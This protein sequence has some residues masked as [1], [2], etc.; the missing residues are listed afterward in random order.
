MESAALYSIVG[1][2]FVILYARKSDYQKPI[3][4]ILDQVAVSHNPT[5]CIPH[6]PKFMPMLM[7]MTIPPPFYLI[8]S[9]Y[10]SRVDSPQSIC[11]KSL[12]DEDRDDVNE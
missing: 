2:V 4:G 3:A 11:R 10:R 1:I 12:V 9:V 7:T 8:S 6:S 5:T